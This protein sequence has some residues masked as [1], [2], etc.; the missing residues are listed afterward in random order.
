MTTAIQPPT[1]TAAIHHQRTHQQ[2]LK[3]RDAFNNSQP[4]GV[5]TAIQKAIQIQ[6]SENQS[7]TY[8]GPDSATAVL[9]SSLHDP[10]PISLGSVQG[11]KHYSEYGLAPQKGS[12]T[13]F[14]FS[15]VCDASSQGAGD[16]VRAHVQT[17]R[18][19]TARD[20]LH[21]KS[22]V[23]RSTVFEKDQHLPESFGKTKEKSKTKAKLTSSSANKLGSNSGHGV[24]CIQPCPSSQSIDFHDKEG[25]T[26]LRLTSP[27]VDNQ[28]SVKKE[29]Q[30]GIIEIDPLEELGVPND[31]SS[32]FEDD[33][34]QDYDSIGLEIPMDD[35]SELQI[36]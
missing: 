16:S 36:F 33:G 20:T 26:E 24:P 31:L 10:Y 11:G 21:K 25:K 12:K 8:S 29:I 17:K 9:D 2:L 34:L 28:N 15:D 32:W 3:A 30:P 35:I 7:R 18:K 19:R 5:K 22:N 1:T 13:V 14:L 27:G 4:Q 6:E 23:K